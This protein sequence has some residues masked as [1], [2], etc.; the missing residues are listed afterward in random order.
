MRSLFFILIFCLFVKPARCQDEQFVKRQIDSILQKIAVEKNVD[1]R[2]T[3]TLSIFITKIEG[4]P[5]LALYTYEQLSQLAQQNNDDIMKAMAFSFA[6]QGYRLSGNYIKGLEYHH[7]AIA[8]AELTN[9]LS[10]IALSQL[11]M[12][13]LYKDRKEYPMAL[14]LY[15]TGTSLPENVPDA[16]QLISWS[17]MNLS[18][19]YLSTNQLDSCIYYAKST[20]NKQIRY[21]NS[22]LIY[23]AGAYSKMGKVDSAL[24]YFY[25][26]IEFAEKDKRPRIVQM[27]YMGFAEHFQRSGQTDS[28]VYYAKKSITIL[29]NTEFAFLALAPAKLLM[30]VYQETNADSTLKYLKLYSVA[31]DSVFNNRANQQLQMMTFEEDLRKR[32]AASE[33]MAYQNKTKSTVL[34][35]GIAVFSLIALILYRNNRQKQKTNKILERTLA[36]LKSTQS[37]LIQSEKMASLGELTAGIAHE[38]QN[39][40]N[41]VNNFSE[42]NKEMA[43]EANI[44]IEKGNLDEVKYILRDIKENSEKINHHGKRADAIVKGML[45]HS[46]SS[47]GQKEP[48]DINALV[49]EYLRLAYHGMSAKD[50]SFNASLTTDLDAGIGT[51]QIV[52]QDMGRVIMNLLN[53][54]FYAVNEKEKRANGLSTQ[55]TDS[56][57]R[58]EV[59][60]STK[61]INNTIKIEVTDNGNGIPANIIEKVFQP[62]FTT[63]PSGSG[64]GLGLSLS[65]DII[66]AHGGTLKVE[67]GE[68]EFTRFIITLPV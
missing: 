6:G 34:F 12:G 7:K 53:N 57:Y 27:A 25:K 31:N 55:N 11:L 17:R 64:T 39:P 16:Q 24:K 43:D 42:V 54:A 8:L 60:V 48:T 10:V 2:V 51:I 28:C 56:S 46:Q 29:E 62:F 44:E 3:A 21:Y 59:S 23:V 33:K 67:A 58:P 9:N 26:A 15:H 36:D 47:K 68:G 14:R 22:T 65:Y 37:Q 13:H 35:A 18:A 50:K 40:L 30:E 61:K 20:I 45:Q 4:Y 49:D 32:N 66:K 38:I 5:H 52:A 41:F 19:V 63:K 1:K